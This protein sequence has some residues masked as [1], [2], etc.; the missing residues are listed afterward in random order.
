MY[1]QRLDGAIEANAYDEIAEQ[2]PLTLAAADHYSEP[3]VR[4]PDATAYASVDS[5]AAAYI[6]SATNYLPAMSLNPGYATTKLNPEYATTAVRTLDTDFSDA[7]ASSYAEIREPCYDEVAEVIREPY[8]DEV[9]EVAEVV[10]GTLAAAALY[11]EPSALR[12]D[13]ASYTL[14]M[15][16]TPEHAAAAMI[17]GPARAVAAGR[18]A[19]VS[20]TGRVCRHQCTAGSPQC[21]GHT[22]TARHCTNA[23]RSQLQL[24][25]S[26][27]NTNETMA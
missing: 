26:C 25:T 18:C 12:Q 23:K 15:G 22:C 16:G 11:S 19:Y 21:S 17:D 24:C 2:A 27:S 9:A 6:Q 10:P 5:D 8:Y 14:L 4:Q 7:P 20:D 3:S 1:G 13:T